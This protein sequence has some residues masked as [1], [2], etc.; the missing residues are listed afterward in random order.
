[1]WRLKRWLDTNIQNEVDNP[2]RNNIDSYSFIKD[3]HD[4]MKRFKDFLNSDN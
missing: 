3:Y 1:M 4:A 2:Y